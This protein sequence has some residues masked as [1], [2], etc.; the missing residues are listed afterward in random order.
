MPQPCKECGARPKIVGRHR[1]LV[2]WVRHE[3]I[4]TRVDE[5]RR[6]LAMVPE[7]LRRARVPERLWPKGQR[8]CAGCQSFVDLV[9]VPKGGS[10]CKACQSAAT[11][12]AMIE[13]TYGL[14]PAQYE[15]LLKRQGGKCA[16]CRGKPKSKRLAVDHDHD[17]GE[18]RGLLCSRCN[19]DLLGAAWDSLAKAEALVTYL[20]TP[21]ATGTWTSP[22]ALSAPES[23]READPFLVPSAA[24]KVAENPSSR[25]SGK[26]SA[27]C[28]R[29][30]FAPVGSIPIEGKPGLH[31]VY[32]SDRP[33]TPPPF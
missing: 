19:H 16:I 9:D 3:P 26:D 30:H 32:A 24:M 33:D 29:E 2:C 7:P 31:I 4:G 18:V 28:E 20:R 1:C 21:P 17:S 22:E 11:H 25:R 13:K 14:T 23:D 27:P 6:R 8:W 15:A 5:A 12:G 10:R